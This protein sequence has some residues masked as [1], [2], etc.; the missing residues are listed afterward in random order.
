MVIDMAGFVDF[1][2]YIESWPNQAVTPVFAASNAR[3]EW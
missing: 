1:L 3:R 2:V